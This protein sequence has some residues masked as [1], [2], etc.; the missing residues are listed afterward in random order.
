KRIIYLD[1]SAQMLQVAK[2]RLDRASLRRD[3]V[4]FRCAP[5]LNFDFP[6]AID[7]IVTQFFL[8]CFE[9]DELRQVV[10][11]LASVL[12][13]DGKWIVADFQVPPRGWRRARARLVLKLAYG[14]FRI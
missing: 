1:A 7:L 14:F 4:E 5:V 3:N 12:T 8:D 10:R 9:G 11:K 2:E 13:P 6:S